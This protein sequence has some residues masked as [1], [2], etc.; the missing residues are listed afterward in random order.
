[1]GHPNKLSFGIK[2]LVRFFLDIRGY[3][4]FLPIAALFIGRTWDWLASTKWLVGLFVLAGVGF[5]LVS[6]GDNKS[7]YRFIIP[8][9]PFILVL[10]T[11]GVSRIRERLSNKKALAVAVTA[12]ISLIL[13]VTNTVLF[14]D[15]VTDGNML[16]ANLAEFAKDPRY[17]AAKWRYSFAPHSDSPNAH[18][19]R[20]MKANLPSDSYIATGQTGQIP[21]YAEMACLDIMGFNDYVIQKVRIEYN[22]G[23]NTYV[24]ARRPNYLGDFD[25]M[26]PQYGDW[27]SPIPLV[28]DPRFYKNY[29]LFLVI[30]TEQLVRGDAFGKQRYVLFK[31]REAPVKLPD[32]DYRKAVEEFCAIEGNLIEYSTEYIYPP[33]GFL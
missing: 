19:G 16:T 22:W 10:I 7:H 11:A 1:V 5:I 29:E 15:F 32:W 18:I 3:I 20:W 30:D 13:I 33:E 6:G 31:R 23:Y 21:Y 25:V 12:I 8:F 24:L 27:T 17:L 26:M 4:L 2:H 28:E 14:E 9:V